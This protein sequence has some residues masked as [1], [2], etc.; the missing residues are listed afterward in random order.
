MSGLELFWELLA[1]LVMLIHFTWILWVIF[2]AW[3]TSGRR[4][5]TLF[6]LG[7]LIYGLAIEILQFYCPL[8][9]LEQYFQRRAGVVP[10]SG[11]FIGHYVETLLYPD[12]PTWLLTTVGIAVCLINL[13]IYGRRFYRTGSLWG[14]A[15]A[16]P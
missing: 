6:H 15:S 12:F 13:G 10:Y 2:G 16:H 8:T 1:T 14:S 5:L 11:D 9:Y 4:W 3:W 7:S